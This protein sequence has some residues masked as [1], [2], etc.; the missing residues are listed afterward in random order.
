MPAATFVVAR[1]PPGPLLNTNYVLFNPLDFA[2]LECGE[3]NGLVE[4]NGAAFMCCPKDSVPAGR[5]Q[6]SAV[7]REFIGVGI[8]GTV[9]VSLPLER[10]PIAA[11]M[12]WRM[13]PHA[14]ANPEIMLMHS[15]APDQLATYYIGHPCAIGQTINIISRV[16]EHLVDEGGGRH[17]SAQL[18]LIRV[19]ADG[20]EDPAVVRIGPLTRFVFTTTPVAAEA[21]AA[22]AA[23]AQAGSAA[24]AQ[25]PSG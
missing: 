9:S 15:E 14:S 20:I 22:A 24:Q 6:M 21:A 3:L 12:E 2:T 18:Q 5:V 11:T 25:E 7:H 1:I 16:W 19:T 23:P 4:I 17:T 13:V 10:P 8:G